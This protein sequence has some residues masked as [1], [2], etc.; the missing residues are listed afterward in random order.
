[1]YD[2]GAYNF[3]LVA[4]VLD[5]NLE[6]QNRAIEFDVEYVPTSVVDGG[7]RK[8]VGPKSETE[9]ASDINHAASQDAV[10][11]TVTS[12]YTVN[13]NTIDVSVTVLN[14]EHSTF[15]GR[16]RAY[17]VEPD[18][19]YQATNGHS[20]PYAFLGYAVNADVNIPG[21]NEWSSYP[22]WTGTNINEDNI[23]VVIAAFNSDGKC[24]FATT[25]E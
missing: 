20:I 21:G 13:G 10:N 2:K 23:A 16:V 17:I 9:Y 5:I 8:K 11:L 25:L 14:N 4:M 22:T 12:G 3:S 15:S 19:R 24:Q 1:M 7:L 18:S 6:A